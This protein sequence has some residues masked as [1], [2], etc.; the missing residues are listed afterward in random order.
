MQGSSICYLH[1]GIV[2]GHD[3]H[4]PGLLDLGMIDV[5]RHMGGGARG[6]YSRGQVFH[7]LVPVFSCLRCVQHEKKTARRAQ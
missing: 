2:D 7:W 4:G 3:K 5:A 6:T 1:K